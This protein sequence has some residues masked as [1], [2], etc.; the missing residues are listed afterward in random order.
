MN[1]ISFFKKVNQAK[2]LRLV[3]PPT[4]EAKIGNI[5]GQM[6]TGKKI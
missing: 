5:S 6:Q 4:W 2:R 1:V 3:I